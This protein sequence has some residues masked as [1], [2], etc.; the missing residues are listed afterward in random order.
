MLR[1]TVCCTC[2]R[3]LLVPSDRNEQCDRYQDYC[4]QV[5]VFTTRYAVYLLRCSLACEAQGKLESCARTPRSR[6][7]L[8]ERSLYK[9][10][11]P[12]YLG[13]RTSALRGVRVLLESCSGWV[14]FLHIDHCRLRARSPPPPSAAVR[15]HKVSQSQSPNK[16]ADALRAQ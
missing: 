10:S 12:V 3:L 5:D 13:S 7:L 14:R 8:V 16:A 15:H 1:S 9:A 4:L 11:C 6:S 2:C